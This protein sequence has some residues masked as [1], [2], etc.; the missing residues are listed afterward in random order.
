MDDIS[1]S[2]AIARGLLGYGVKIKN[3]IYLFFKLVL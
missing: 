1:H 2:P 3:Q